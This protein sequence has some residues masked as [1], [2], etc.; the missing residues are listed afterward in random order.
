MAA[1]GRFISKSSE[2]SFK[3]FSVLKKQN[4]FEWTDE[5]QQAL[6]KSKSILIKSTAT[7]G[8]RKATLDVSEMAVSTVLVREDKGK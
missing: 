8:W 4:Q 2:K 3:F 1:L 7:E 6:K 5:C